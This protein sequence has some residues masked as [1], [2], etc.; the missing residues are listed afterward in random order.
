M[1]MVCHGLIR[2]NMDPKFLFGLGKI[3][4][5]HKG[6]NRRIYQARIARRVHFKNYDGIVTHRLYICN[7]HISPL[8]LTLPPH[9]HVYLIVCTRTLFLHS[10]AMTWARRIM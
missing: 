1:I 10:V 4:V 7:P 6:I 8:S 9:P 2:I 5:M 3:Q